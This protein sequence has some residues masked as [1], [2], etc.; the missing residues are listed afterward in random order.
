MNKQSQV[1]GILMQIE[2]GQITPEEGYRRIETLKA[3][4]TDPS[5]GLKPAPVYDA[6]ET[7]TDHEV[8]HQ[9]VVL[10]K[11][12]GADD[13][14][15][16]PIK[17][18]A[19]GDGEVQILVKAFALNFGDLLC[20]KGLYPTMPEYPFV[21]GF[22]VSGEVMQTGKNV[23]R[24]RKGDDVI[25]MTTWAMGGHSTVANV[26]ER[27]V[28]QKPKHIGFEAACAF[29][30]VYL[31]M[32][33]A[34]EMGKVSKDD[35]VLIQ[36]AAGGTGLAA[37][38]MARRMGADI[39]ATAGSE[40]KLDYLR[41]LGITHLI[42]YR[43]EDFAEKIMALTEGAGVDVVI[44]TLS[45]DAIQ[46]GI[47]ILAPGG[48]YVEIAMTG[49]KS[50]KRFDLSKMTENQSFHSLNLYKLWLSHPHRISSDL[51]AM[52][53][54]LAEGKI[55]PIVDK[56]FPLSEVRR[57]YRFMDERKN[58]GKIV[59][60]TPYYNSRGN[61]GAMDRP[62]GRMIPKTDNRADNDI[63]VI[64]LSGCFPG[65]TSPRE[66]WRNLRQGK[67]SITL[68]PKERWDAELL[69]DPDPENIYKTYCKWGGFLSDIDKFDPLF[70]QLSGKEAEHSDP[71]Q[72]LFLQTCWSALEDA[73]YATDAVSNTKCGVFAGAGQGDYQA[74]TEAQSFLGN[75][76]SILAARISYFL[77]LKGPSMAID[78]ACS[79][80]LVAIHI[81]CRS[82]S[83]G[84][85]DMAIAGGV[86]ICTTPTFF[87]LASNS[88]ML[89]PE[90]KCKTFDNSADGFVPGEGVGAVVLKRLDAAQR[91]GDHIYAVIKGSG[92]N[93]DGKTN[94][95]T[96]PSSISQ[97]ELEL[98]VYEES[99]I[100]P[101]TIT[102][103]EAHGTGTKL[104][105]PIEIEALTNAFRK[106]TQRN[107]YCAIGSVKTNIGHA[108]SAAGIAGF[109]KVVL[110]LTNRQIP[111]SLNFNAPN[112][113][114]N[115]RESPFYVSTR[116]HHWDTD[117][118]VPRRAAV[119]AFGFS[120]TNAH[121]VLEE[122]QRPEV[123]GERSEVRVEP[124]LILLSARNEDRLIAYVE[125]MVEFL[126]STLN[127]ERLTLNLSDIAYTLQVGRKPM[128]ERLALVV[129][130]TD[131]LIEKLKRF[132]D[133]ETGINNCFR[134]NPEAEEI[135]MDASNPEKDFKRHVE[136]AVTTRDLPKL[137][138]FWVTGR[139][140]DWHRLYSDPNP[141]RISLPTYPFARQRYW[142]PEAEP[143]T[144][145]QG[146][147]EGVSKTK[148][149][150]LLERNTSSLKEQRFCTQ[151]TGSEFYMTG[152]IVSGKKTMPGVGFME[153]AI[154]AGTIA[155][156]QEIREISHMIWASPV[157]VSDAPKE[158]HIRLFPEGEDI[159]FEIYTGQEPKSERR[160]KSHSHSH[161]HAFGKLTVNHRNT[162]NREAP[163]IDAVMKR[164]RET[165]SP[166]AVYGWFEKS[167]FRYGRQFQT[168]RRLSCNE[169]EAVSRLK[170]PDSLHAGFSEYL[171]HPSLMD[172]A[173]QT[174][175]WLLGRYAAGRVYVPFE[176]RELAWIDAIPKACTVYARLSD[177]P[178]KDRQILRAEG[179]ILDEACR[180]VVRIKSLGMKA[181][182]KEERPS[183]YEDD[184]DVKE[185][186][187]KLA[188]GDLTARDADRML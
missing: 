27:L 155:A 36:T 87:I 148:L 150:P 70:F 114:I 158:V 163:D 46:K 123:S 152:H 170:L 97:T 127:S 62:K 28:V 47:D 181:M 138:E 9:A 172:G 83:A 112:Q 89:S 68:A 160:F 117:S 72:R 144:V 12:G 77:N 57:A 139:D 124:Q 174:L 55:K 187:R 161:V 10:T 167:G 136:G 162:G 113:H 121:L 180:V 71:Q 156:E 67:S 92:I 34:F 8:S 22:E 151:I 41:D 37:V 154:A 147:G 4:A 59:V 149:H 118:G 43:E 50:S 21:P 129:T 111:P 17:P 53:R 115:F 99:G 109:I 65:A 11:P 101:D 177:I 86:F 134:G 140:I 38:Q 82:L 120:G 16:F 15:L 42:N 48:R 110:A 153:M 96:A 176:I 116:P 171:L 56:V 80:S 33:H 132:Q 18:T 165:Y 102:L 73:G 142:L 45:G 166:E 6:R 84:E 52:A 104:G 78:T 108:A 146:Q 95:I 74:R 26:D 157:T 2:S 143:A 184:E 94:G 91:D 54:A 49:L 168:I 100:S 60:T 44:N 137:A 183:D 69:Y 169:T 178:G 24:V 186:L 159:R 128:E 126:T 64:G 3:H 175:G 90:G 25:G 7:A 5:G 141:G 20:V 145:M 93:Q 30:V 29:P 131:E 66:F 179:L 103:V 182:V 88:G 122:Y 31:T 76:T 39:Y 75:T 135:P 185:I 188:L 85:I 130:D 32:H 13:I 63:A 35:R 14:R 61:T 23:S 107:Q 98:A 133:G 51:D 79:S 19:P 106:Y 105:D 119:S 164:S 40:E 173:F 1:K 125:I 58:I 81:A